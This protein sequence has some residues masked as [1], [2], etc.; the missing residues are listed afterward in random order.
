M[1]HGNRIGRRLGR[2]LITLGLQRL[3]DVLDDALVHDRVAG[4]VAR[5]HRNSYISRNRRFGRTSV[6]MWMAAA[7]A[8]AATMAAIANQRQTVAIPIFVR[9]AQT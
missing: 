8:V 5:L 1:R 2:D 6:W 4:R 7:H 9:D 3:L